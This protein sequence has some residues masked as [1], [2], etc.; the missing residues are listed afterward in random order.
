MLMTNHLTA[1][2]QHVQIVQATLIFV[3]R[4]RC[5]EPQVQPPVCSTASTHVRSAAPTPGIR[6]NTGSFAENDQVVRGRR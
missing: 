6:E 4:R 3:R 1:P 2:H 5:I